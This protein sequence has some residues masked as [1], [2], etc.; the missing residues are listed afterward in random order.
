MELQLSDPILPYTKRINFFL[1][2]SRKLLKQVLRK[3]FL[4]VGCGT[5]LEALCLK[6]K[7]PDSLIIGVDV[8]RNR[9]MKEVVD[10]LDLVVCDGTLLPFRSKAFDFCYCYQVLEHIREFQKC[11][12]EMSRVL[13]RNG[14]LY[15]A[16]PNRRRLV[17]YI[18]T[19]QKVSLYV[20]IRQNL[21]EWLASRF[22]RSSSR[23]K[24]HCGFYEE[25]L[26]KSL[27]GCFSQ[28]FCVSTD[29]NVY[30]SRRTRLEPLVKMLRAIG[31]LRLFGVSHTFYCTKRERQEAKR[32][33]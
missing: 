33:H 14:S 12:Y 13:N 30:V 21:S 31:I 17:G 28:V 9:I 19:P 22:T 29:Y 1:S 32:K 10:E 24:Y 23:I 18:C 27:A 25:E 26:Q 11:I 7:S 8:R 5:G 3:R 6:Q 2:I 15:L 4:F 20:V 16:T